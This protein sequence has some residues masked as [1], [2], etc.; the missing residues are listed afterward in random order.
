MKNNDFMVSI[1]VP[2]FNRKNLLKTTINALLKLEID[3]IY[4]IIIIDDGSKD[5]TN[6]LI[7]EFKNQIN[8]PNIKIKY[9]YQANKGRSSARNLGITKSDGCFI[10]FTDSDCVPDKKWLSSL[11]SGFDLGVAGVGGKTIGVS[12]NLIGKFIDDKG[13]INPRIVSNE[14]IYLPTCNACYKKEILERIGFFNE[15]LF[16][17]QDVELSYRARDFD[18]KLKYDSRAI[19]KHHHRQSFWGL[20]RTLVR[21]GRG[22]FMM[23]TIRPARIIC[24]PKTLFIKYIL[25]PQIFFK[26]NLIYLDRG[27]ITF[28]IYSL[29]DYFGDIF[30]VGGYILQEFWYQKIYHWNI[31]EN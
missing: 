21:Y 25:S 9:Y 11:L 28:T 5:G 12:P 10:A 24:K 22:R 18:Y 2:T 8:K 7:H 13:I 26:R 15:T 23:S 16:S 30:F 6:K 3:L 17:G 1:V 19:V 4:E 31:L 20:L 27:F 29:L 14:V